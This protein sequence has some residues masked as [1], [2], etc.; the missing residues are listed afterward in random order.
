MS[1]HDALASG[2]G[3]LRNVGCVSQTQQG[4]RVVKICQLPEEDA[5]RKPSRIGVY[6][7]VYRSPEI[8]LTLNPTQS[9]KWWPTSLGPT[10]LLCSSRGSSTRV[11]LAYGFYVSWF[12]LGDLGVRAYGLGCR[13]QGEGFRCRGPGV[14]QAA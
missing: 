11:P 6:S 2:I 3:V 5:T 13:V 10:T 4:I 12:R 14:H 1:Q 8:L 7:V 9:R